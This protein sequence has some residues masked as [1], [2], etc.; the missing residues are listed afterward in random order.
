[1]RQYATYYRER[2]L[3]DFRFCCITLLPGKQSK[4]QCLNALGMH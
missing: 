1:M 2:E 4:G 3:S